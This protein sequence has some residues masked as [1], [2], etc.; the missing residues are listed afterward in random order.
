ME[1]IT[2]EQIGNLLE[3]VGNGYKG[4]LSLIYE[5]DSFQLVGRFKAPPRDNIFFVFSQ[6]EIRNGLTSDRWSVLEK[7]LRKFN[8]DHQNT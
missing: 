1:C 4:K 8:E 7:V 2:A 6:N 3:H 5:N